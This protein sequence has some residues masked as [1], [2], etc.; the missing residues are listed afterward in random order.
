MKRPYPRDLGRSPRR[1]GGLIVRLKGTCNYQY[2]TSTVLDWRLPNELTSPHD[3]KNKENELA[4]WIHAT[5]PPSGAGA[6]P[7]TLGSTSILR[8]KIRIKGV[9]VMYESLNSTW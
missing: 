9:N 2:R 8:Y 7:A 5:K 3:R 4:H 6:S 1:I